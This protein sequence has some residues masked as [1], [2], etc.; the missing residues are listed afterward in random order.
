M[1]TTSARTALRLCKAAAVSVTLGSG[2]ILAHTGSAEAAG[3]GT[4][5]YT[6]SQLT[7]GNF[8][9]FIGDKEYSGFSFTG[10]TAGNYSFSTDGAD[11]TFTGAGLN[12]SGSGFTYTYSVKLFSAPVGQEFVAFSTGISTSQT[13]P[14]QNFSKTL[15]A[16]PAVNPSPGS[17][18][19]NRVN[20]IV[21]PG[22]VIPFQTGEHGPITFTSSVTRSAGRVDVITDS[23]SQKFAPTDPAQSPA[24]LPIL[25]AGAAFGL[26]RKLR[27]RI[28][29][30]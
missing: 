26:S 7:T 23:I 12:Y 29:L 19:A 4:G 20:G 2:L 21:I 10:I 25:G 27:R 16:T 22:T 3:C 14:I 24:P 8:S 15:T 1:A 5:S 18:F 9:C 11:H 28:K 6:I 30:A 13:N 17:S